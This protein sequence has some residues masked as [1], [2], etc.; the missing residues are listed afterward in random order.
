MLL[1]DC[2]VE[3]QKV[4]D[5]NILIVPWQLAPLQT[6]RTGL[7]IGFGGNSELKYMKIPITLIY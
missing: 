1:F 2:G 3:D 4:E 5:P 6:M 7:V